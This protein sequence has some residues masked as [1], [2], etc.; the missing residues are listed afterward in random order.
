M[1]SCAILKN[2]FFAI[3]NVFIEI[4]FMLFPQKNQMYLTNLFRLFNN[5]RESTY[6]ILFLFKSRPLMF[7]ILH[8]K[9]LFFRAKNLSWKKYDTVY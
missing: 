1:K 2:K 5:S 3:Q 6:R 9:N 4:K 8:E 7:S